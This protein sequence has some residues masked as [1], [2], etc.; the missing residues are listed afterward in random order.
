MLF[1]DANLGEQVSFV[2][3]LSSD[4]KGRPFTI[5]YYFCFIDTHAL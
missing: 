5:L 2:Y 3:R 1:G 4:R